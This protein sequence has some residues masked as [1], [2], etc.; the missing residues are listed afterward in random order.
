M[1]VV[2]EEEYRALPA[3]VGVHRA[4]YAL[5]RGNLVETVQHARRALEVAAEDDHLNRGGATALMGLAAWASGD[6]ETA[7]QSYGEGMAHVE[8]DGHLSGTVGRAIT[9]ADIRVAQ[10]RLRDAM[11]TYEQALQLASEQGGAG[12]RATA[13]IYVGMSELQRER[14]ELDAAAGRC[15][16]ASSLASSP[17]L[18]RTSIGGA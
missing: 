1:V 12:V 5:A 8:R 7:Y 4:G 15:S 3:S 18:R 17:G 10:G 9:L 16:G 11:H 2:N 14:N 13:D 6:L